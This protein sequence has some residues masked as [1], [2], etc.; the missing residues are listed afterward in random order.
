MNEVKEYYIKPYEELTFSDDFMF[1]KTMEDPDLCRDVLECLLQEPV[2]KLHEPLGQKEIRYTS[3]G[4][5]IRLDVL[6]ADDRNVI[7]DAEMQNLNKKSIESLCLSRRS[8]FYQSSID[9]DMMNKG[10]PYWRLP[11][12]KILFICTFDPY[13]KGLAHYTF[14]QIC[15]E[16]SDIRLNDG[17]EKILNNCTYKGDD[18]PKEMHNLYGYIR[19]GRVNDG[20]TERIEEAVSVARKRDEWRSMYMK[21]RAI[22]MEL[23]EEG[24]EVVARLC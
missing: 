22:F 24:R 17:T 12:S 21:E 13:R 6:T 23:K 16:R 14:R 5:P 1:G 3:D 10:Y 9:T 18:L 2:G 8:R 15:E 20:L 4:K 19:T 11:D 7:Y